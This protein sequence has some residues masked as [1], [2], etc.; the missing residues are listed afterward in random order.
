MIGARNPAR[1][2]VVFFSA[3]RELVGLHRGVRL[4]VFET[5]RRIVLSHRKV[6]SHV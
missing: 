1:Q 4:Q 3:W 5:T 2:E 6:A